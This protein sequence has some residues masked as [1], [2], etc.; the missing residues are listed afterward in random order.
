MRGR[1]AVFLTLMLIGTVV[2]A[3][4]IEGGNF[5][6]SKGKSLSPGDSLT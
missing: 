2:T 6:Y 3:G 1:F 5:V 4:C